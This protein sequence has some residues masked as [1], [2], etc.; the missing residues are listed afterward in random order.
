MKMYGMKQM[1]ILAIA[2]IL[3]LCAVSVSV[4]AVEPIPGYGVPADLNG[5]GLADDFNGDGVTDYQ[6]AKILYDNRQFIAENYGA[7][8]SYFD[9]NRDG[10]ANMADVGYAYQYVRDTRVYDPVPG[11]IV[12]SDTNGDGLVDDFN[13]DGVSN[14]DD[15]Q[16][17]Y[18]NRYWIAENYVGEL[19]HMDYDGNGVTNLDDV[20]YAYQW[21]TGTLPAVAPKDAPSLASSTFP[22]G[23]FMTMKWEQPEG[24]THDDDAW[25]FQSDAVKNAP[26][27]NKPVMQGRVLS[28]R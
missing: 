5:D 22:G 1:T 10:R 3:A 2:L 6:D 18:D 17:L 12:P 24:V 27:I 7:Y 8:A 21:S 25:F 23:Y 26:K 9:Y 20:R 13:G 16:I 4:S 11:Y 19:H 15:V 28:S 14:T